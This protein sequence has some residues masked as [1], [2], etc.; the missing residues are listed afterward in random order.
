M[1]YD[2]LKVYAKRE[3]ECTI[4]ENYVKWYLVTNLLFYFSLMIILFREKEKI[5]LN[6]EKFHS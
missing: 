5:T 3:R 4:K 2:V 1:P 6:H